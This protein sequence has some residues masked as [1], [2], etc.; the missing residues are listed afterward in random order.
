MSFVH[1]LFQ[2]ETCSQGYPQKMGTN[3]FKAL[4]LAF[5]IRVMNEIS[6]IFTFLDT[7]LV[8]LR[9]SGELCSL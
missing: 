7:L 9:Q 1:D 6:L 3:I 5:S 2:Q 4:L 8:F